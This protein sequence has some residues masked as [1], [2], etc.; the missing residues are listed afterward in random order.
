MPETGRADPA[1]SKVEAT[2]WGHAAAAT[3]PA[4]NEPHALRFVFSAPFRTNVEMDTFSVLSPAEVDAHVGHIATVLNG[5]AGTGGRWTAGGG[6]HDDEL[7]FASLD[8]HAL[9]RTATPIISVRVSDEVAG[10]LAEGASLPF[11]VSSLRIADCSVGYYDDTI[12]ILVCEVGIGGSPA[13]V[14]PGLDTWSTGFCKSL[15]DALGSHRR[16]LEKALAE[17]GATKV[18]DRLFSRA[19]R[20][21]RF[22]DRNRGSRQD[23]QTMLW[24]N[25]V[26]LAGEIMALI[27]GNFVHVGQAVAMVAKLERT[28]VLTV[29]AAMLFHSVARANPSNL[30]FVSTAERA[31]AAHAVRHIAQRDGRPPAAAEVQDPVSMRAIPQ[32]LETWGVAVDDFLEETNYLL[33]KPSCNPFVDERHAFPLSQ[34][35][36]LAPTLS[37]KTGA[38]I[39]AALFLMWAVL[40]WTK[41][42]LSGRVDGI[43][44]DGSTATSPLGLIQH[45]K[46]M[47]AICERARIDLGRRIFAAGSDTSYGIEDI[48]ANGVFTLAQLEQALD[49]LQGL[50]CRGLWIVKRLVED[51][52]L[53]GR[54]RSDLL[55]ACAGCATVGELD[56]C[57]SAQLDAGRPAA[58][59]ERFRRGR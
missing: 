51:F 23:G 59:L 13:G 16:E 29:E 22:S 43:P 55:G 58:T 53:E 36:F 42:L 40:G 41:H 24:V 28:S 3:G 17:K 47:Q 38:L 32:V 8:E 34:A 19:G 2:R 10:R 11:G 37:V 18:H 26:W 48:W 9:P 12:A 1:S 25:R 49:D 14:L 56:R 6:D 39:E 44:R 50:F 46:L 27:N 7:R 35:S 21:R 15:I 5:A 57:V 33:F 45:P 52:G 54:G 31:W 20:L 30:C 4:M